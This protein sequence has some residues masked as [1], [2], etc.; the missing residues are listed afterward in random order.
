MKEIKSVLKQDGCSWG[1]GEHA[2]LSERQTPF[3]PKLEKELNF[4]T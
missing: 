3:F 2:D 1:G 4:L